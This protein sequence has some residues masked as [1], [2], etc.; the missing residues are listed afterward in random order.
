SF[1]FLRGRCRSCR[2]KISWQYPLVEILTAVIFLFLFK[3]P[4]AL[5]VWCLLIVIMIYDWRHKIIPDSLVLAFGILALAMAI[6]NNLGSDLSLALL[7]GPL[8]AAPFFLLWYFSGGKWMGLGDAKLG[9]GLG[10]LLGVA[11][12]DAFIL[13]F[14]I[15]AT[16]SLLIVGW[17]SWQ[18]DQKKLTIKSEVPFAPFLFAATFLVYFFKLSAFELVNNLFK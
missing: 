4:L 12:I 7:W 11:S 8:F 6:L 17:Q 14:W 18:K 13:A 9:L 10:W 3:S 16:V 5:I 15:G 2:A 1:I